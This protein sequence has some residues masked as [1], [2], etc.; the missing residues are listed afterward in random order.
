MIE[1]RHMPLSH[2]DTYNTAD[3]SQ[4]VQLSSELLRVQALLIF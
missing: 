4:L 1:L 2:S 3:S